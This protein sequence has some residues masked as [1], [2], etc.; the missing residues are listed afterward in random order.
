MPYYLYLLYIIFGQLYELQKFVDRLHIC[1]LHLKLFFIMAITEQQLNKDCES[2]E[3]LSSAD[4]LLS[5]CPQ[6]IL[7][8]DKSFAAFKQTTRQDNEIFAVHTTP[9]QFPP[10]PTRPNCEKWQLQPAAYQSISRINK[11]HRK[12]NLAALIEWFILTR[13][14]SCQQMCRKAKTHTQKWKH[15]HTHKKENNTQVCQKFNE[16]HF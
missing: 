16:T 15:T 7:G 4:K 12:F 6:L 1:N 2:R 5:C 14:G 8:Y 3:E 11:L 9:L 13:W 10:I